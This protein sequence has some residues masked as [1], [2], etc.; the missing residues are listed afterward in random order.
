MNLSPLLPPGFLFCNEKVTHDS[1]VIGLI[2]TDAVGTCPLCLTLTNR[3]HSFYQRTLADLPMGGKRI[4]LQVRLRKFFCPPADC[5]RKVFAQS[6]HP[7]CKPYARRLLRADQQIQTIGLQTGAKPGA[8]LCHTIGQSVS[9]STILRIIRRTPPPSVETP[10]RL[11]VDDF[12]FKI[13]SRIYPK[14]WSGF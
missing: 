8:R 4:K 14:R 5:P 7:V 10:M 1:L 2:V 12:A 3:A 11:G 9:A 6:C 13:C